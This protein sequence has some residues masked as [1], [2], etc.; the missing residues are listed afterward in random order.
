MFRDGLLQQAGRRGGLNLALQAFRPSVVYLNGKFLGIH[1]I[2]EKV[3]EEYVETR[4]GLESGTFDMIE[5]DQNIEAGDMEE[6]NHYKE[7]WQKDLSVQ[8]NYDALAAIMDVENFTDF[9]V[10]QIWSHNTSVNHNPMAWKPK[11]EGVWRWI[12]TDGDRGFNK[13]AD[14]YADWYAGKANMPF[15]SML[16]N[17]G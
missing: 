1:N 6:W 11:G 14:D 9:M 3:N 8:S 4:Y 17:D 2:R 7:L 15:G 12:F 16:K 13:Y 10:A 5:G